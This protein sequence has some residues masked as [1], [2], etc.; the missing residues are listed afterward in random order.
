MIEIPQ[1][2][3]RT[4]KEIG[5]DLAEQQIIFCLFKNGL[6]SVADISSM[7]KLPR[8]T[9]HLAT[10]S[11]IG[12][13]VLATTTVGKRRLIYIEDPEKIKK[14]VEYEKVKADKKMAELESILPELRSFFAIR[15]ENEKIDIEHLEGEAGF[16]ETF[17][18]SL[19]QDK[20]G[21][22]LRIH[23][24]EETFTVA[25]SQLKEYGVIRRKKHILA[26]HIIS[27]S[28]MAKAEVSESFVKMRETRIL[29]KS[30][31]KPNLHLSIWKNHVSF[32]I[33]D[34]GLHSVIITNKSISDFMKMMFEV[35]WSQAKTEIPSKSTKL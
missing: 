13:N 4:L 35:A 33:W 2:I 17:Y 27:D 12:K 10:E 3:K 7:V 5:F 34:K 15:G 26:R 25:R 22:V 32:T 1:E 31:I 29:P 20:Y 18:R 28:P 19:N 8:S 24:G 21:E 14:F 6:S 30:V 16:V 9:I 11:L 23:G